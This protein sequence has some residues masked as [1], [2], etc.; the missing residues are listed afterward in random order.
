MP[1]PR[2][3]PLALALVPAL[4]AGVQDDGDLLSAGSVR[5]IQVSGPRGTRVEYF[6]LDA[7]DAGERESLD[8]LTGER[9]TALPLGV[10]RW[11]SGPD[12][13][14]EGGWRSELEVTYF[15][16]E[17]RVQ[18][19]ERLSRASRELIFREVRARSGRTVRF[20][21]TPDQRGE[22]T[23]TTGG[24]IRRRSFDLARGAALPLSLV[25]VVRRGEDWEGDVAV[26]RPTAN[27]LE[28]LQLDVREEPG[29]RVLELRQAGV[30]CGRFRFEGSSLAS[31]RW[32]AGGPVARA[33]SAS[34]YARVLTNGRAAREA[35]S[36]T[37][38]DS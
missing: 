6:Q 16:E 10:A 8:L 35:S 14:S 3:V 38:G 17:T 18:H 21:W 25:E 13:Q 5:E 27:R 20:L 1:I 32:Q 26:F 9:R 12:L 7:P 15:A 28:N 31:F 29:A 36:S 19:I 24:E 30:P 33:L 22:S 2:L 23:V 37:R 11:V 4:P 34:D